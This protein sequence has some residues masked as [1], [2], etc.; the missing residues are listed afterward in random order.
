MRERRPRSWPSLAAD[1][2]SR[3]AAALR[4]LE[5]ITRLVSDWVWET[6]E[7]YR[8]TFVSE[9]AFEI[10]GFV[11]LALEG[12]G[13]LDLGRFVDKEGND[14]DVDLRKPFR[15]LPFQIRDAEGNVRH[16]L[17]SGIPFYHPDDDRFLGVRGTAR[18]IT[19]IIEAERVRTEQEARQRAFVADVA[20]ELR[21]PL[22][23]LR[24]NLDNLT[25]EK[26]AAPLRQDVDAMTR[27]ISQMLEFARY[28][29]LTVDAETKTDLVAVCTSVATRMAPIAISENRLV[30]VV[31]ATGPV[32]VRGDSESLEQAVRNL[33]ENAIRYAPPQT[34]VTV[35]V[36][37]EP[38][39]RVV[40]KGEGV[41]PEMRERIFGRFDRADRR[42]GGSG[43]G[44]AIV[45]RIANAHRAEVTIAD[46][47]GGGTEFAI[48]FPRT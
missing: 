27:L 38:A 23:I 1:P 47:P 45:K 31:G 35:R 3:A 13:L 18:D 15:D 21:T 43:L 11:P 32:W 41:P 22:A 24:T 26:A 10:F 8:L 17:I 9:S 37:R 6:D 48:V 42:S 28:E 19:E 33:I 4:R 34:A 2:K 16:L 25:D 12:K 5:D 46:P 29:L 40:D 14:R 36:S 7:N 30:E 39:I 44:L 20:H